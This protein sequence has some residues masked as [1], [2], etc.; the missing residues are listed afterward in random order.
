MSK[1]N[2]AQV[3]VDF[4]KTVDISLLLWP[5]LMQIPTAARYLDST[6]N[7]VDKLMKDGLLK[8]FREGRSWVV[9]R[10]ELDRYIEERKAE[11][12]DLFSDFANNTDQK[13]ATRRGSPVLLNGPYLTVEEAA[14]YLRT[15]P[16]AVAQAMRAGDLSYAKI[17]KRF[18]V[19]VADLNEYFD[20]LKD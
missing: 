8:P 20:R 15:T 13:E 5:R 17:G 18:V 10:L 14:A 16:W 4:L 12:H 7:H 9:D 11:A 2:N 3:A 19:S 1:R 6:V